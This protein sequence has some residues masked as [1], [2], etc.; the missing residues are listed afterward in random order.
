MD[1]KENPI[2][3]AVEAIESW[4]EALEKIERK[5]RLLASDSGS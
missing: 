1:E 5:L 4:I 2:E 3:D